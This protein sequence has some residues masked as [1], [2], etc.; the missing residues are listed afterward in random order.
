MLSSNS[1][2]KDATSLLFTRG[3]L[4]WA[5]PSGAHHRSQVKTLLPPP[6]GVTALLLFVH[7]PPV[8]TGGNMTMLSLLDVAESTCWSL[9]SNAKHLSVNASGNALQA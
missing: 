6:C 9:G 1:D 7:C 8:V 4:H 5:G 2:V 3:N